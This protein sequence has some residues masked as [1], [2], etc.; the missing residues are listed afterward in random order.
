MI[1]L[2]NIDMEET[3]MKLNEISKSYEGNISLANKMKEKYQQ[4]ALPMI[5]VL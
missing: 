1:K 4:A 2:I 3:V 5:G